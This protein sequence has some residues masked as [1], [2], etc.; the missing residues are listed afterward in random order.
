MPFPIMRKGHH[1]FAENRKG[2]SYE[3]L[4]G[5]YIDGASRIIVT[6]SIMF[7]IFY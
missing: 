7:R 1:V 4:F 6:N 3:K 2:V 5:P